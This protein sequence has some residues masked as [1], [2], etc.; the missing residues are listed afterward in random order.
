MD[1]SSFVSD[2]AAFRTKMNSYGVPVGISEDWDR[3]GKMSSSDGKSLG[4]V[5]KQVKASSD[6]A[7]AHIMPY[8]HGSLDERQTWGYIEPQLRFLHDVVGMNGTMVTESQWAWGPN[9]AHGSHKDSSV[10]SYTKYWK[11]FDDNCE[12]M[13]ELGIGWFVHDWRGES[14]FDMVKDD[15]SYV[16]PGWKPRKC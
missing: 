16:I 4:S 15:G 7:H 2:L 3:P 14:T 10:Q 9:D 13:K 8:Y 11:Q 12:L 1:G 6:Y 5:G